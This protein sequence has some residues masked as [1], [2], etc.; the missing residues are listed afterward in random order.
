MIK[1]LAP[2]VVQL[3]K[4][5]LGKILGLLLPEAGFFHTILFQKKG[6]PWDFQVYCT[7]PRSS[8]GEASKK[9]GCLIG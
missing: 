1:G 3:Y 4:V 6:A 5:E 9:G 2:R 7:C 8:P